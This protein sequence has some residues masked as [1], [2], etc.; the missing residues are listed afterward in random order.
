LWIWL[1]KLLRLKRGGKGQEQAEDAFCFHGR[2]CF[3]ELEQPPSQ[4]RFGG[5]REV[6]EAAENFFSAISAISC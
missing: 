6:T 5:P 2:V 4:S 1:C 3:S